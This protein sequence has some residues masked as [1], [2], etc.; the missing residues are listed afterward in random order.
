[1][2]VFRQRATGQLATHGSKESIVFPRRQKTV[3]LINLKTVDTSG[4][5]RTTCNTVT[6]TL[7]G[8]DPL[9]TSLCEAQREVLEQEIFSLLIRDASVLPT[10]L[11]RVA[12]RLLVVEATQD[13]E[14]WFE[15][16]ERDGLGSHEVDSDPI[17]RAK[18]DLIYNF[19]HLLL[20]REHSRRRLA[21]TGAT[22]ASTLRPHTDLAFSPA[23]IQS[24]VPLLQPVIDLL[25]YE[26]FCVRVKAEMNKIVQILRR[27]GVPVKFHFDTVGEDGTGILES[28]ISGGTGYISGATTIRIDNSRTLRFTF[29]SPSSLVAHLSQATLPVSSIPQ[30]ARLLRDE[31]EQCLL[32][33]I[34]EMGAEMTDRFSGTWLVD[35]PMNR[36]VGKWEG[37]T[38]TFSVIC[39]DNLQCSISQ[40]GKGETVPR[41][42]VTGS[43]TFFSWIRQVIELS[44]VGH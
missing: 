33:R 26:F 11:A 37:R 2:P 31:T 38:L 40:Y 27:A 23:P 39:E 32:Q 43:T 7:T 4:T 20:L 24:T 9:Q 15:L 42:Y 16:V 14:I 25:Q 34:C 12:E 3:L 8:S 22:E 13:T 18:C 30:L 44:F 17:S 6:A 10:S 29:S 28:L 1:L 36:V 41:T 35:M 21:R 19:L 5:P